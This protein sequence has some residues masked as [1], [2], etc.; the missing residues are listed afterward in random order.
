MIGHEQTET[1]VPDEFVVIMCHRSKHAVA[2]IRPTELVFCGRHT[3]DGDEKAAAFGDPLRDGV[4]QSFPDG[5]IHEAMVTKPASKT[6][7]TG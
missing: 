2:G 5:Q 3:F 1:A 7:R 6:K 4:W